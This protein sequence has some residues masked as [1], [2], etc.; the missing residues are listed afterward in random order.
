MVDGRGACAH[1]TGTS[2]MVASAA[3]LFAAE[4]EDHAHHGR[5]A[6]CAAGRAAT[7]GTATGRAARGA[8]AA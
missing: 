6:A 2:R 7:P 8:V 1:P 4:L 3:R 5:C